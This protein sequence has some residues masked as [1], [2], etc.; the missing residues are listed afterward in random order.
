MQKARGG[1]GRLR[2][3]SIVRQAVSFFLRL[4]PTRGGLDISGDKILVI[5]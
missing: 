4:P 1:A 5:R 3:F 2:L